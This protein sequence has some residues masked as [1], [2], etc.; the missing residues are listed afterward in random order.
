[1]DSFEINKIIAAI[2]L[3]ALIVI[4][5]GKFTDILFHVEKPK[6]SAYKI[7]GLEVTEASA[8]LNPEKKV[9]EIVNI[10][11]LLALGDL[12]HGEK[13][14]KKCSA[15]HMIASGGKNMIGPN[16]WGVIGRTAGSVSDYKYSKAMVAY[17]KQWNFEEMNGY[18]IKP[19]AYIK[20]TKMAF[21]G[22]RKEKD[23]A[24]VILYL[25][26]KSANPKPL[27]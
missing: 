26:S 11:Q 6:E 20:G 22:L 17:A 3:T 13:V 18:L 10:S 2:L 9:E 7:E 14:F 25:N 12:A 19:Q 27:P 15:C 4:G 16:L 21:A 23:R 1:M 24:S 5:I 8:S